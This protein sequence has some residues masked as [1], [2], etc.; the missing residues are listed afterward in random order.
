MSSSTLPLP[1]SP[2]TPLQRE[3]K[4]VLDQATAESFWS[5]ASRNLR[6]A[7]PHP[8]P[9]YVRTTYFDTDDLA[10]YRASRGPVIRSLRVREYG[11][12]NRAGLPIM[13]RAC[14]VE[15]KQSAGLSLIHI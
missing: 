15:L 8:W 11:V 7:E 2:E 10:Y 9:M 6:V 3:R 4:F 5:L 14:F 13:M 1:D 12:A